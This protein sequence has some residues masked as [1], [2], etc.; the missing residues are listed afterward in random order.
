MG[1]NASASSALTSPTTILRADR[2]TPFDSRAAAH[3][4][5]VRPPRRE[6]PP[7]G[8][9]GR[10]PERRESAEGF[11]EMSPQTSPAS[12]RP[13]CRARARGGPQSI[14]V[15]YKFKA[16]GEGFTHG[17]ARAGGRLGRASRGGLLGRPALPEKVREFAPDLLFVV[18]GATSRGAGGPGSASTGRRS[19]C[20]TSLTRWTT[21][22]AIRA[23]SVRFLRTTRHA[24]RA[25]KRSLPAA[26][27]D[28]AAHTYLPGVERKYSVGFVGGHNPLR[29]ELLELWRGAACSLTSSAGR[30]GALR[31]PASAS[32]A[33]S[34]R[35]R[36]RSST[37]TRG[38]SSTSSARSTI[39]TASTSPPPRSTEGLR[40]DAVRRLVVSE[41]RPELAKLCPELPSFKT[42]DELISILEET[43]RDAA[44]YE[45][46]RRACI[47]RLAEHTYARRL[48]TVLDVTLGPLEPRP[49]RPLSSYVYELQAE[50]EPEPFDCSPQE[51]DLDDDVVTVEPDG[52]LLLKKVRTAGRA[53]KR[54]S[55][56]TELRGR[57]APC[58]VFVEPTTVFIAK[59]H[60]QSPTDQLTNSYHLMGRGRRGYFARHQHVFR[61]F[62]LLRGSGS[63]SGSVIRAG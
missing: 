31:S 16:C 30:G 54:D 20:S 36:R 5:R 49:P 14:F 37:A 48:S 57:D 19:G 3:R 61:S 35:R 11:P 27:Y 10:E 43:T 56:E 8:R 34:L 25:Q 59:I 60:Q 58:E 6:L 1:A 52:T 47:R 4:V 29:E 46:L 45:L 50:P 15:N 28:P 24:P 7:D 51:W 12:R 40:G 17:L 21:P 13:P 62:S 55:R 33:S 9:R 53:R 63:R 18:H 32:R 2:E 23:A 42:A 41:D 26:C 22:C 39:S 44:R 38:S